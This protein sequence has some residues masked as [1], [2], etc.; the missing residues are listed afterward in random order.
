MERYKKAVKAAKRI[1][2]TPNHFRLYLMEKR[3]RLVAVKSPADIYP[4][5]KGSKNQLNT[6]EVQ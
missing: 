3:T 6:Y 2:C 1:I 5:K 4:Y